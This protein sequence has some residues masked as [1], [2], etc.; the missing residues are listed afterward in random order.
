MISTSR[1]SAARVAVMRHARLMPTLAESLPALLGVA[2]GA[3]AGAEEVRE[4][5]G[6]VTDD[7]QFWAGVA[8]CCQGGGVVGWHFAGGRMIPVVIVRPVG[9]GGGAGGVVGCRGS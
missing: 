3:A 1:T 4:C 5:S 6:G 8:G 7:G 2:L 9:G